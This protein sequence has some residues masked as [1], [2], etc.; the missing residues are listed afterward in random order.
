MNQ[1]IKCLNEYSPTKSN[2]IC[3]P[4]AGGYSVSFQ[5]LKHYLQEKYNVIAIEPPGHGSNRMP[6]VEDIESL[7]TIYHHELDPFLSE[8]TIL[9]GH[10]MGGIVVF[11]LTQILEKCGQPPE[12][13]Y[14]SGSFPPH[15]KMTKV[16]H[17]NKQDFL[18][19]VVSLG[20]IPEKLLEHEELLDFFLPIIRSDFKA[21]E[22][23]KPIPQKIHTPASVFIGK[24]DKTQS[25]STSEW[26]KWLENM[27]LQ[28]FDGGHMFIL[29]NTE[30]VAN[31]I[32]K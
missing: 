17:L 11:R 8:K 26:N 2:L 30:D 1:I 6:L 3:F 29:S 25:Y 19:Y 21:I 20:G 10:S 16:S 22:H 4:F 23:F 9:F 27:S 28:E 7:V 5:G 31:A 24:E 12:R 14:L 13:I 32:I 15:K 18:D